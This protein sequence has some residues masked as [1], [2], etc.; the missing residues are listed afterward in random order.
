M[1]LRGA[2]FSGLVLGLVVA[3]RVEGEVSEEFTGLGCDDSD[4]EVGDQQGYGGVFVSSADA[5]VVESAVVAECDGACFV[6]AVVADSEV[7]CVACLAWF[8]FGE[9]VV[10]GGWGCASECAVGAVVVV[11]AGE[12]V[13]E[14]LE[15]VEVVGGGSRGEPF[16]E[17]LLETFDFSAG[18]G[19]V[20]CR[21]LL[22]GAEVSE[23]GLEGVSATF[24]AGE[25][26]GV[27]H[28][29]VGERGRG[30]PVVNTGLV[31]G[32]DNDRSGDTPVDGDGQCAAGMV[33]EPGDDLGCGA[34]S[35]P[36]MGEV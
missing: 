33:I 21:V 10:D 18:G 32:V 29:V 14:R 12:F 16:F 27:D 34:V 23:A 7:G 28:G 19:V 3:G 8:G 20:G 22:F 25:A 6:D 17:G 31:E 4:V 36:P 11:G 5:D 1:N 30:N 15:F 13:E 9:P 26:G 24:P 2:G 35:E